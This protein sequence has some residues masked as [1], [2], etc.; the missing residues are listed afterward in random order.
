MITNSVHKGLESIDDVSGVSC[1]VN[2]LMVSSLDPIPRAKLCTM[3]ALLQVSGYC[4]SQANGVAF[5]CLWAINCSM[6]L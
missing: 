5:H 6:G 2:I 3:L 1:R 4:W